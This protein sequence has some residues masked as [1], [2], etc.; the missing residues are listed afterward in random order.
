MAQAFI[1]QESGLTLGLAVTIIGCAI[2][3]V[4]RLNKIDSRITT[5]NER[6][7]RIE[8][9]HYTKVEAEAHALRLALENPNL[10]VPDPGNPGKLIRPR[11]EVR[12]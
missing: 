9:E 3:I 8:V 5:L 4:T 10:N 7:V 2:W 12:P 6:L 1:S 11:S